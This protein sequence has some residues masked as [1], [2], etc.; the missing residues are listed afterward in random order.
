MIIPV[1]TEWPSALPLPFIDYNGATRNAT[2]TSP[3]GAQII[4]RRSRFTRSYVP[5][6][7][8][9]NFTQGEYDAFSD[10]FLNTLGN[11]AALFSISLRYPRNTSLE[12]WIVRFL[13]GYE[14]NGGDGIWMVSAPIDLVNKLAVDETG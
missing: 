13:E 4:A 9:W 7:V 10:F 2:I 5:L 8:G 11:G 6:L 3:N 1:E 14:A 12:D